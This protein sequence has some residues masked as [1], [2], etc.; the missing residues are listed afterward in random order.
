MRGGSTNN[1]NSI[2]FFGS[3]AKLSYKDFKKQL[4]GVDEEGYQADLG[5][6]IHQLSIG[7]TK[8][9]IKIRNAGI[10]L[11]ISLLCVTIYFFKLLN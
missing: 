7:L 11:F 8:K 4:K 10:L 9:Y 3:I 5:R 1:Y 2:F 6:Q